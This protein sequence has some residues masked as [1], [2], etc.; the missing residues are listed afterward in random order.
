MPLPA[1]ALAISPALRRQALGL[2]R[3]LAGGPGGGVPR[4]RRRRGLDGKLRSDILWIRNNIGK[5]AAAA[6]LASKV[7]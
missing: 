5:T 2:V 7:R 3:G 1:L 4:R 6:Y